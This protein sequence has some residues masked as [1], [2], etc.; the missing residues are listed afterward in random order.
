MEPLE[1]TPEVPQSVMREKMDPTELKLAKRQTKHNVVTPYV[2]KLRSQ[3]IAR[4]QSPVT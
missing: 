2:V 3:S 1:R 4:A